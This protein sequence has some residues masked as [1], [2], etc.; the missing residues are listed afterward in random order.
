M[1]FSLFQSSIF[2]WLTNSPGFSFRAWSKAFHEANQAMSQWSLLDHF[3]PHLM[4]SLPILQLFSHFESL[5]H[6]HLISLQL[7]STHSF[8]Q[9]QSVSQEISNLLSQVHF[10]QSNHANALTA[11]H[12]SLKDL[13]AHQAQISAIARDCSI[14]LKRL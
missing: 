4:V 11:Y 7:S 1:A 6:F 10:P 5:T 8:S 13:Q 3:E 14:L 9:S 12:I 2:I